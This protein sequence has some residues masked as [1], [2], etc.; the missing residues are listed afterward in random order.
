MDRRSALGILAS[1]GL[2]GVAG[3]LWGSGN[4]ASESTPTPV[5]NREVPTGGD[6][7]GVI[8]QFQGSSGHTG[9]LDATGPTNG[10]T[11]YWRRTP[12]RYDH[13]Q[14]VVAD[15]RAYLSFGGK[16]VRLDRAT[17][18]RQWITD[19]G[20]DGSSTPAVYDGTVYVTVWNGGENED[21]GLAAVDADSGGITWRALTGT[22]INS[23][24]AVT[25]DGVFVGGGLGTT[26]VAAF[27][28]DG[29]ERWR[30]TLGEYASTP[31][32]TGETVVYGAGTAQVVSY[33]A[34][35]GRQLWQ[36]DTDG[37]TTAA[38][39]V[40]GNRVVVGTQAGTLYSLD[41][42][43]GSKDWSIDLPGSVRRSVAMAENRIIVP[44]GEG[45]IAVDTAGNRDWTVD[46][47][48]RAT[49]PVIAGDGVYFGDR[50][51]LRALSLT[52]GTEWWSFETRNRSFSDFGLG[53]IQ[54]APA[55]TNG[56]V[57]VA[58]QAGDVYALGEK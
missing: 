38:P 23:S 35:S 3:C 15:D 24:P 19:I 39:T 12:H 11:T 10:V 57:I 46:T 25:E 52:D 30:H 37:E 54:R 5:M 16:L 2:T 22:D 49:E 17:G 14:P 29:T 55:I 41:L 43:D 7:G 20:H 8:P 56:I 34:V 4:G 53:G 51:I 1:G 44:T 42:Q 26:S 40:A 27:D 18:Q 28:H 31:A 6:A 9:N 32:V 21:R 33:D 48:T 36:F 47:S 13:S 50:R 58:T 45:L